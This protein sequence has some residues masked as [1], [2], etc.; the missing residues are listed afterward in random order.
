MLIAAVPEPG[1]AVLLLPALIALLA[2]TSRR[3]AAG[4]GALSA[5]A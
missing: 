1:T 4:S 2:W 5:A 3:K